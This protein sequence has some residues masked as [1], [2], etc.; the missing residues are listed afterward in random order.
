MS[1]DHH[2]GHHHPCFQLL[3]LNASFS[4]H[5]HFPQLSASSQAAGCSGI[6]TLAMSVS[7]LPNLTKKI[8]VSLV[9]LASE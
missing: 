6:L 4:F 1:D 9:A 7:C 2:M 5:I 8:T 3:D